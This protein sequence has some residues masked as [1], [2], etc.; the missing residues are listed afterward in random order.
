MRITYTEAVTVNYINE[1]C[2]RV[3]NNHSYMYVKTM[4]VISTAYAWV[5][6]PTH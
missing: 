2:L 5:M 4:N 3:N 6:F 1:N